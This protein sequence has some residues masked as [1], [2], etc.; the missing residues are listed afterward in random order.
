[1]KVKTNV[2]AGQVIATVN[3]E[4]N[5]TTTVTVSNAVNISG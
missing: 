3:L 1:M 5:V 4:S 2:K